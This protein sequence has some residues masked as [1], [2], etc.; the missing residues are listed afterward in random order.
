MGAAGGDMRRSILILS[1]LCVSSVAI[2]GDRYE[3]VKR[4]VV[5]P[6]QTWFGVLSTDMVRD[7]VL[8]VDFRSCVVDDGVDRT[9]ADCNTGK[10]QQ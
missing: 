5:P 8:K 6:V 7:N 2:A 10:P 9:E 3:L 1:A 4:D